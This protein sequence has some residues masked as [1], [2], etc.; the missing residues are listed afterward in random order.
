M[1]K[2]FAPV[3]CYP[4]TALTNRHLVVNGQL[5]IFPLEFYRLMVQE[6]RKTFRIRY[7]NRFSVGA[8]IS[9]EPTRVHDYRTHL[10]LVSGAFRASQYSD[11]MDC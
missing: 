9:Y 11:N 3:P 5:N 8:S 7:P 10:V 4:L 2:T 1:A 6:S